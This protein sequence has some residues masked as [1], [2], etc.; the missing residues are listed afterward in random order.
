MSRVPMLAIVLFGTFGLTALLLASVVA[1]A[2]GSRL[3]RTPIASAD[4]LALRLVPVAGALLMVMTVICPAFLS[5]EPRHE[6]EAAGPVL[7]ALA[8][9]SSLTLIHGL[10]RGWRACAAARTLLRV[11]GRPVRY[12]SGEHAQAVHVHAVAE[13]I[14]GV[15]GAWRPQVIAADCAVSICTD[16]EFR[17]VI[18]HEVAHISARDNLKLLFMLACPDALAWTRWGAGLVKQW[19]A[20]AE[21]EADWRA[22]GND[23]NKRL[24]L[25][26]AV[27]KVTRLLEARC[28]TRPAVSMA[29]TSD[30]VEDRVRRLLGPPAALPAPINKRFLWG[31]FLVPVMALPIYSLVHQLVEA[32]VRFGL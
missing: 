8:V 15:V 31:A 6:R 12:W 24:V 28:V 20:A 21:L 7:L 3:K 1:L 11:C 32:L 19:R 27:L 26:S 14:I 5:Y 4:L 13:P 17:Q 25:A 16:E 18:E 23:P 9:F 2:W 30:D 22:T 10:W 29:V